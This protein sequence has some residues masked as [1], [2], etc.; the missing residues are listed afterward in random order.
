MIDLSMVVVELISAS[1]K[2]DKYMHTTDSSMF[3]TGDVRGRWDS[4]HSVKDSER[5]R[6]D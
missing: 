2:K 1:V 4:L 3:I 6:A 5:V